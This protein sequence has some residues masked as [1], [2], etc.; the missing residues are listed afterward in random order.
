MVSVRMKKMKDEPTIVSYCLDVEMVC[1]LERSR[2][3]HQILLFGQGVQYFKRSFYI[4]PSHEP[5]HECFLI[6]N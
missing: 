5:R 4:S 1:G 3:R 6:Y 2:R